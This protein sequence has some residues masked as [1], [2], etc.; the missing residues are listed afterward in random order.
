MVRVR[1]RIRVRVRSWVWFGWLVIVIVIWLRIMLGLGL[2]PNLPCR[3]LDAGFNVHLQSECWAGLLIELAPF[4]LQLQL[5]LQP[6]LRVLRPIF[7]H[8]IRFRFINLVFSPSPVISLE[9]PPSF[10]HAWTRGLLPAQHTASG[11]GI[12]PGVGPGVGKSP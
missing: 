10:R 8:I 5:E 4:R 7:R 3:R 2:I 11:P 12:R 9:Q 1:V 6:R